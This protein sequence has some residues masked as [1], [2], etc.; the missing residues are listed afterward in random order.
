MYFSFDKSTQTRFFPGLLINV[1]WSNT[2]NLLHLYIFSSFEGWYQSTN[3]N[4]S[5]NM[6]LFYKVVNKWVW[7]KCPMLNLSKLNG[8]NGREM[9]YMLDIK[10]FRRI[11]VL[12]GLFPWCFDLV[13][14]F[15]IGK[16]NIA[17][18]VYR[19]KE[20]CHVSNM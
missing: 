2:V 9:V 10:H 16:Q 12:W 7:L 17:L 5:L 4:T 11:M 15:S 14:N 3:S 20:I 1:I 13:H 8:R 19:C 6:Q 18:S